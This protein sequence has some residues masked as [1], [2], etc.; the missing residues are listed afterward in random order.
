MSC[1]AGPGNHLVL[2]THQHQLT[3][4]ASSVSSVE[5]KKPYAW[6]MFQPEARKYQLFPKGDTKQPTGK[7][8]DPEE[9]QAIALGQPAE[10]AENADKVNDLRVRIKDRNLNRRRKV[11]VPELGPMTTVHEVAMDSPTIPGRPAVH[12][13]SISTP[14]NTSWFLHQPYEFKPSSLSQ[15]ESAGEAISP[16]SKP[17]LSR[18]PSKSSLA[19]S[20]AKQQQQQ[21]LSPKSLAPLTIPSQGGALPRLA[22][23]LSLSR[24]RSGNNHHEPS[25]LS[26]KVDESNQ[27]SHQVSPYA[28][29]LAASSSNAPRSAA[30]SSTSPVPMSAPFDSRSSP[31]PWERSGSTTPVTTTQHS[32]PDPT[33]TPQANL[34]LAQRS[35]TVTSHRRNKSESA[36]IMDRG[37]PR[38]RSD[39][40][41]VG[42][43][44]KRAASK[45]SKDEDQ[46]RAFEELPQGWK[47]KEAAT[48]LDQAE[49]DYLHK[50]ALGQVLRFEVLKKDDV[51]SLSKEL[52]HLDERT[53]YLRRT[54]TSL[55]AG[56]RNLHTRICQY[57]RSPRG[58]KFSQESM[59]K[60]EEALAELDT[61][62][63]DW[64]SKL[65]HA[66][67]RRTRVRQKLLEH[68]A[69]A[70]TMGTS[71]ENSGTM[72]LLNQAMGGQPRNAATDIST[73]PRSPAKSSTFFH[74]PSPSPS[75]QRVVA[76]VP[77]VIPELPYEDAAEPVTTPE[78][79]EEEQ[80]PDSE[81]ELRRM[82]SIRIYADS[83][84]YA[85]LADVESEF[86]RMRGNETP[87]PETTP[88]SPTVPEQDDREVHR[89]RSH[90]KLQGTTKPTKK[91]APIITKPI[92]KTP[93]VTPPAPS[94]PIK[95]SPTGGEFFLTAAVFKP[96]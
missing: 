2:T 10:D 26:A 19:K 94:P 13:R 84:V 47:P 82:E 62:I 83:D 30:T 9:A 71:L 27:R 24:L 64:V 53:E 77:S 91:P 34:E 20:K 61:S 31:R 86:T 32:H 66:E 85:L 8:L 50:Q 33:T 55:R 87:S 14:V 92:D 79:A 36:S 18:K 46:R 72:D 41:P 67:N 88:S 73:P 68:V 52:R 49:A 38:K 93:P 35:A 40:T 76:R 69:A 25:T 51:E 3:S 21:Q 95:D 70:A 39:G 4:N 59:L 74:A 15:Q 45:K 48:Q 96:T 37:R 89:A 90:E 57:L 42:G 58:A 23:Q 80:D 12:E 6:R 11:S 81:T 28:P 56:R 29:T 1:P 5:E 17:V 60:Q 54:Y 78:H 22:R 43:G 44:L 63:D 75:P 65:E 7:Q 16:A